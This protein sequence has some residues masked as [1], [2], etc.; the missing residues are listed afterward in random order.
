MTL[1]VHT[2]IQTLIEETNDAFTTCYGHMNGDYAEFATLAL[3]DFKS[4]LA[5]PTLTGSELKRMLRRGMSECRGQDPRNWAAL[6]AQHI[7]R[8]LNQ[9]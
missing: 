4:V 7:A 3:S 1:N 6:M 9:N 2:R 5:Q 8:A